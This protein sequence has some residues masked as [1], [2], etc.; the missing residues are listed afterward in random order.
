L[1]WAATTPLRDGKGVAGDTKT[2]Y[3]DERIADRNA[4][5]AEIVTAQKIPTNDLT[6]PMRGHPEYHSDNVHFN[7]QGI[8]IQAAQVS[9]EVEKLLR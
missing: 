3:S 9:A 1:I 6:A 8:K 4:I 5:A 2:K 7:K